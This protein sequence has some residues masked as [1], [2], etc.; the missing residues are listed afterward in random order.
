MGWHTSTCTYKAPLCAAVFLLMHPG[1]L[2]VV[3]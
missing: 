3:V 2:D 1:V